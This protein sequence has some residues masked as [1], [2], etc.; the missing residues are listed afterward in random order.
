VTGLSS[1]LA[2]ALLVI[3]TTGLASAGTQK[4]QGSRT[5]AEASRSEIKMYGI[6]QKIPEGLIGKWTINDKEIVVTKNT[7]IKEKYGKA[8]AGAFVAVEAAYNGSAI[9][10]EK[11]EV[12]RAKR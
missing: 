2:A 3:L 1:V 6:V 8:E 9:I 5:Y 12:K 11:I 7:H 10:A 4:A